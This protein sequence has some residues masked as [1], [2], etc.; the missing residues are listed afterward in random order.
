MTAVKTLKLGDHDKCVDAHLCPTQTAQAVSNL[1]CVDGKA[2]EYEC[3]NIDLLSF[4]P[5]RE[6][7]SEGDG[8]DMWGWT[9]SE[10][11]REYAL[12]GCED[13]TSFVDITEPTKPE[14]VGFLPTHTSTSLWRDIKVFIRSHNT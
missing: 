7:G 6:L 14:V 3:S 5:L 12:V 4:V 9:D 1:T 2:D 10:T 8:T 11:D 13:G